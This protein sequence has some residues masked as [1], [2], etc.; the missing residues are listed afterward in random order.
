M[1]KVTLKISGSFDSVTMICRTSISTGCGK[2][3]SGSVNVCIV[4]RNKYG[5]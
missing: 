1:A 3:Y 5:G 4:K 2:T